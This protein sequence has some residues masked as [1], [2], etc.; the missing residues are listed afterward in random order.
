MTQW[1]EEQRVLDRRVMSRQEKL[2]F[3][4]L[5]SWERYRDEI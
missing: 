3:N 4:Y 2:I 1:E 5:D